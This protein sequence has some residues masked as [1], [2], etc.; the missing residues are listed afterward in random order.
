MPNEG[1]AKP[2]IPSCLLHTR[3]QYYSSRCLVSFTKYLL[4]KFQ[5]QQLR[6]RGLRRNSS[7][8]AVCDTSTPRTINTGFVWP[9]SPSAEFKE[10]VCA[11]F[12]NKKREKYPEVAPTYCSLPRVRN[13]PPYAL[14]TYHGAWYTAAYVRQKRTTTVLRER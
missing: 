3:Y 9:Y 5:E 13:P 11:L 14:P 8:E 1:G 12:G 6:G 10:W 4:I 7:L 2:Y